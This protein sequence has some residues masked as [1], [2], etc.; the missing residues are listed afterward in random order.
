[1]KMLCQKRDKCFGQRSRYA[2][3]ANNG[4][5]EKM[6]VELGK[7]DDTPEDPYKRVFT[8]ECFEVSTIFKPEKQQYL[9]EWI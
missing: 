3:I 7:T 6:F 9:S 8:R 4:V 1:M 2:M 5:I